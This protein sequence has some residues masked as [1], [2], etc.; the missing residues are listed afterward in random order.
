MQRRVASRAGEA[1]EAETMA[2][3]RFDTRRRPARASVRVTGDERTTPRQAFLPYTVRPRPAHWGGE[4]ELRTRATWPLP[5]FG[6]Q[7][8][9][10]VL[11]AGRDPSRPV[12][13]TELRVVSWRPEAVRVALPDHPPAGLA[14]YWLD[15]PGLDA[16]GM[17]VLP[18]PAD[19]LPS[20]PTRPY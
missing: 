8:G 14:R 1:N 7:P 18:R 17:G 15:L 10:V 2:T 19:I 5:G 13:R 4:V 11:L 12:A 9:R 6:A 3:Q 20:E 16:L